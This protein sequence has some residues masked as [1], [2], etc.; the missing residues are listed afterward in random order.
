MAIVDKLSNGSGIGR[1]ISILYR[2]GQSYI[3][4]KLEPY[5]IGSG[6]YIFLVVL[7]R[8][9]GI[10]QE[11]LSNHLKMDKATVA[12]ALK[13]LADAGYIQRETD[14]ADKRAYQ[15]FLTP[16]ALA[17]RPAV[18]EAIQGWEQILTGGLSGDEIG[19]LRQLLEKMAKNACQKN[20]KPEPELKKID[21]ENELT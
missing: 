4:K 1:W 13:K 5:N 19:L 7:Y 16:K 17:I 14:A 12:K 3:S 18:Q 10:S 2:H 8:K 21:N 6:Q 9:D 20:K 15:V 11:E